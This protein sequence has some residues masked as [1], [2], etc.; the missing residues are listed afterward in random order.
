MRDVDALVAGRARRSPIPTAATPPI[1]CAQLE[2]FAAELVLAD[3]GIVEKRLERLKKEKGKERE[4]KL[5][6]RC[7]DARSRPRQPLRTLRARAEDA[8]ALAGL[9]SAQPHAAA[10]R[11]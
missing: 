6:E 4:Q 9:R 10:G 7:R 8:S 2:N 11:C 3:L 5:L 1:R